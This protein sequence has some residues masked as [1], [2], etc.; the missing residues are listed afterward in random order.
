MNQLAN[1]G[2]DYY[3]KGF[4]NTKI[5]DELMSDF[6]MQIYTTEWIKSKSVFKTVPDW[7]IEGQPVDIQGDDAH[8]EFEYRANRLNLERCP[9]SLKE[10][11]EKLINNS[12]FDF[13]R[14]VRPIHEISHIHL[15]NGAEGGDYHQDVID[16]TNTLVLCYLTETE[17][18]SSYGGSLSV[19][20]KLLNKHKY[21][22]KILPNAG[23]MIIINND[24]PLFMHKVEELK[25]NV[26]R[27]TFAFSYKWKIK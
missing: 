15:W 22:T 26:N 2:F 5:P 16:G 1:L 21:T 17:W 25:A 6:W 18:K 3:E 11:S 9:D 8:M 20:K 14:I 10:L 19:T 27:Y 4:V 23:T 24:N 7:Y 13:L 12:I